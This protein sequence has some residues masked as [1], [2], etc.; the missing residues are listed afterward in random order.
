MISGSGQ[1]RVG[2]SVLAQQLGYYLTKKIN[3]LN[4]VVEVKRSPNKYTHKIWKHWNR[5]CSDEQCTIKNSWL[6]IMK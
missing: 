6:I 3:K 2:K 1:V 4:D 5:G